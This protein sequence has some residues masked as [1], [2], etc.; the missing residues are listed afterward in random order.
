MLIP[1]CITN[2][3]TKSPMDNNYFYG[4]EQMWERLTAIKNG[5]VKYLNIDMSLLANCVECYYKGFLVAAGVNVPETVLKTSH[6]LLRLTEEIESRICPLQYNLSRTDERDRRNFLN[7]LSSK[8]ITCRYNNEQ[9]PKEDFLQCYAWAEKQR[10]IVIKTLQPPKEP[11]M[12]P[13]T[14]EMEID[15]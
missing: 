5:S 11:Q 6:S 12:Q 7:D 4:A 10:E 14:E 2:A 3:V 9:V 13:P 15:L 8:Y 1:S